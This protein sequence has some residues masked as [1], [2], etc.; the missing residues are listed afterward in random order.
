MFLKGVHDVFQGVPRFVIFS[1]AKLVF[2]TLLGLAVASV[3]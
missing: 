3:C 2:P 1:V